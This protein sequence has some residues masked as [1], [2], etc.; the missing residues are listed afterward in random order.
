ML[1]VYDLGGG[2]FDISLLR[3]R[4]GLFE[5]LAT[6]GDSALG[7]DVFDRALADY[8]LE[9]VSL[10]DP[11]VS[12]RRTALSLA[13]SAKEALSDQETLALDVSSLAGQVV[14][15]TLSREVLERLLAPFIERTLVACR[16]TLKDAAVASVDRVVL[17]GGSTRTPAVRSPPAASSASSSSSSPPTHWRV[18][19][20]SKAAKPMRDVQTVWSRLCWVSRTR[21]HCLPC[22]YP[23]LYRAL[24]GVQI[25]PGTTDPRALGR[26]G[27]VPPTKVSV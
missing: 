8:L 15:V 10:G 9:Q 21:F 26:R 25:R 27:S 1:A 5:V 11:S 24:Y 2:T 19:R 7:G 20:S 22:P 16:N 17:V 14:E 6:G 23:T 12:Q 3:M 13:R 18:V 4:A